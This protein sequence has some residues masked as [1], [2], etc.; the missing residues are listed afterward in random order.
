MNSIPPHEGEK[1]SGRI[2][3]GRILFVFPLLIYVCVFYGIG[4]LVKNAVPE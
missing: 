4:M 1:I 2:L 3:C